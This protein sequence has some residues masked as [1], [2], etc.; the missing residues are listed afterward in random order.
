M[1]WFLAFLKMN[2]TVEMTVPFA[3]LHFHF[4]GFFG[5]LEA[6]QGFL[7]AGAFAAAHSGGGGATVR[8]DIPWQFHQLVAVLA[9]LL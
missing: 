5:E 1:S 9:T 8:A 2:G 4:A 7:H 6:A 3:L